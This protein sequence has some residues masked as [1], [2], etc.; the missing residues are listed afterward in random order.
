MNIGILGTGSIARTMAAEFAKVPAFRCEAVCSRQQTTGEALAQ[1]FGIPK[2]Y[3]DYDAMLADP[4]IELVYIATPNS[5][6][7]AQTKAALLAG[8]N[9]LCEKPFVPTVAEADELIALAKE[10][11]LFLFEA[12]TTAHHPNYALAKQYLDD[13]GSLRIVSCTFCQYS[14]RYDALLSG[15]VPPVFDPA[16]CGGALMD[17][18]V[19][20]VSY[21]VGLFGAP[22]KVHYAANIARGIDTSGVLTME[23][24][25]FKA[26]SINAK[27]SSSPA[28]YII[29]GTK[30]YLLQKSTANFCGGVTFHPYKG[31][32]EHFNLSAGRP[33]QA[34]EFH[35]IA[36]AIE[37]GDQELCSRMLDTSVAVSRVLETARR[38]AGIRFPSE[39]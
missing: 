38:D 7:Y 22:N 17:L 39:F 34:A 14:S 25:S 6:H 16:C 29:Q 12:I 10:K 3:T 37:S 2:V 35:A 36:R 1:Q 11:H 5:L 4:D 27:D 9:V 23:Y 15:Q 20:N 32:E 33:R 18:G 24:R 13:I 21:V 8:K 26:V 30:G 28:R 19:Y 31:R